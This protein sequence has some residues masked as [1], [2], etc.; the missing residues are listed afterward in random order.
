M[1]KK[2]FFQI[3]ELKPKSSVMKKF[4]PS[5]FDNFKDINNEFLFYLLNAICK[6]E[7]EYCVHK[8]IADEYQILEKNFSYRLYKYLS[9]IVDPLYDLKIHS[10]IN[11]YTRSKNLPHKN[12]NLNY[13]ETEYTIGES[14]IP[15]IVIHH[16]QSNTLKQI[17]FGEIKTNENYN[18]EKNNKGEIR[19][20]LRDAF[21]KLCIAVDKKYLKFENAFF[22]CVNTEKKELI[23]EI[24]EQL[25]GKKKYESI[26][27]KVTVIN[28]KYQGK[29]AEL[30]YCKLNEIIL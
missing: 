3:T 28:Y 4:D 14:I 22:I 7:K 19:K 24:K 27:K 12:Y 18:K 30:H 29:N 25:K 13:F 8:Y 5:N 6:V 21:Y 17:L 2:S 23:E 10:E 16:A 15:D 1:K 20:E 11:K 26:Y 9:N